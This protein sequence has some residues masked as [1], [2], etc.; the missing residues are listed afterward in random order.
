[1]LKCQAVEIVSGLL[2]SKCK[3]IVVAV[4]RAQASFL[5]N[6]YNSKHPTNNTLIV[7]QV[8]K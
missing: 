5:S 2:K 3:E 1:M 8:N 4:L 6:P 7:L